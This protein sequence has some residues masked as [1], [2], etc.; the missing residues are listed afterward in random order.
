MQKYEAI[1]VISTKQDEESIKATVE[2][3]STLISENGTLT[4]V[5]EWGK[6]KLAYLINKEAE[7]YYVLFTFESEA[8]FPAELDRVS[9]ITDGVLRSMII[10]L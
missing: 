5:D 2:K 7:G 8:A 6:R 10:A 4:S 3:F 9:K 1:F